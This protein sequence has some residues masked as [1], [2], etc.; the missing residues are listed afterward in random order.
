MRKIAHAAIAEVTGLE[1]EAAA[2]IQIKP[3]LLFSKRY[4]GAAHPLTV[5]VETNTRHMFFIA[6]AF[7][8]SKNKRHREQHTIIGMSAVRACNELSLLH[9]AM[10]ESSPEEKI[11]GEWAVY[12]THTLSK[13]SRKTLPQLLIAALSREIYSFFRYV[14]SLGI[15][16]TSNRERVK[17][18]SMKALEELKFIER[19]FDKI[20]HDS[21]W[22]VK[23][24][25]PGRTKRRTTA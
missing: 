19:E 2:L 22:M 11:T 21:G 9:I 1:P 15:K 14:S 17:R 13:S 20:R 12:R 16:P 3:T 8:L 5:L 6:R 24:P 23:W 18:H 4:P 10:E 25:R 7:S